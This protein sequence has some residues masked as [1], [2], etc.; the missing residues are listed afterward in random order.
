MEIS[1]NNKLLIDLYTGEKSNDKQ[2][3]SNP[4]LVK[5]YVKTVNNLKAV[6]TI[7]QHFQFKSLN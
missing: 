3:R 2:F 7:A 4:N 1:F 5:Q 6:V